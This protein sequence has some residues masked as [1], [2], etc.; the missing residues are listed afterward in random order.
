MTL[1]RGYQSSGQKTS[2]PKVPKTVAP[3]R[4]A[5]KA[6]A[7]AAQSA[8]PVKTSIGLADS[9]RRRVMPPDVE[10]SCPPN[11]TSDD[12]CPGDKEICRSFETQLQHLR[13]VKPPLSE[14]AFK[15]Y[16]GDLISKCRSFLKTV[17]DKRR[18]TSRRNNKEDPLT[19]SSD[20]MEMQIKEHIHLLKCFLV[21]TSY[22]V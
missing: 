20:T 4:V 13:T 9:K 21:K 5:A 12:M 18:S 3:K 10:P 2:E 1:L 16:L 11:T 15:S 7:S 22:F 17:Q 19:Q 6:K 14:P 8:A